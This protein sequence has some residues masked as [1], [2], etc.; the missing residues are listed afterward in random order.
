MSQ[1][2]SVIHLFFM[3]YIDAA[4]EYNCLRMPIIFLFSDPNSKA[5]HRCIVGSI[6]EIDMLQSL[7]ND[8]IIIPV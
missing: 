6:S 2:S 5:R 3:T 4:S 8:L 1:L 7:C